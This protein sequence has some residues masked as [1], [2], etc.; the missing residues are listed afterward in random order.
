MPKLITVDSNL[1]CPHGG[2][3]EI[4][5]AQTRASAG[6]PIATAAD[7]FVVRDCKFTVGTSPHP[8]V[9]VEWTTKATRVKAVNQVLTDA[10]IGMC[11]AAD[12]APQ[13]AVVISTQQE[14]DGL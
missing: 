1:K 10:C 13:G 6:S 5:P 8:C 14:A 2:T 11:Y 3:V 7:G 4:V 9:R 12:D